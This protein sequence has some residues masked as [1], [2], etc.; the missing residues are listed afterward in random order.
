[1]DRRAF[2]TARNT[3]NSSLKAKPLSPFRT[4]SGINPYSG[5]W[6]TNEVVHLLKRT[7]FGAKKADIDYFKTKSMSQ[8][9][10]ELLTPTAA[11]PSPPINDYSPGTP[12]P[13]IAAGDTWISN[14]TSDGTLNSVRRA[15]F[16]K[17]WTGVMIN[18]DRSIREKLTLFWA[19]HFST[20]TNDI[21]ISHY[22]YN[23]HKLLRQS[24]LGNSDVNSI[25]PQA[26]IL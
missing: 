2:L 14:P 18:Q 24:A 22:V 1:M 11:L 25:G 5:S 9:V 26:G 8:A 13:N 20:E 7:M 15:S 16:K 17:W 12:D 6:T 21:S 10:D 4:Y 3:G 23:H 19:N